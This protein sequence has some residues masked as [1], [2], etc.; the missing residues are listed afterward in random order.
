[1]KTGL[2]FGSFNP[3]HIGHMAIANYFV[4]F[5]DLDELWFVVSPHNPLKKK[6]TLLDDY[7]RLELVRLAIDDDQKMKVSDIEFHMPQPSYT[8]D[9]LAYLSEKFPNREFVLI[10]GSDGLNSFN[11][12]KN[13]SLIS[14]KYQRYIY[15]RPSEKKSDILLHKNIK[16]VDAPQMEISSTFI[17]KAIKSKKN[18]QHFLPP[19]VFK[20]IDK[21]GYYL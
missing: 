5:T 10:M 13:S 2:Y 3:I 1:M 15:P 6:K 16:L 12:W 14:E 18:I 7:V 11:K 4:E 20:T 9:T 17:R 21:Y 8:I 19:Q